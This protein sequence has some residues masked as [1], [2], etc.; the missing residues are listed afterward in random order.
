MG[1][2]KRTSPED[3]VK[4]SV[5]QSGNWYDNLPKQDREYVMQT[6]IAFKKNPSAAVYTL[7]RLL[8]EEIGI[9]VDI[10]NIVRKIR[11][12]VLDA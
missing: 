1:S 8:K 12:L 5:R 11:E 10:K 3:L 9:R 2:N 7:A 4:S 6:V